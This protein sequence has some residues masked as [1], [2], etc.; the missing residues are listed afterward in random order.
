MRSTIAS[1]M[2]S[3]AP[4]GRTAQSA[5]S[6]GIKGQIG[7]YVPPWMAEQYPDITWDKQ[8]IDILCARFVLQP[9][10]FDV[11]VASNMCA[12]PIFFVRR[13][14]PFASRRYTMVCTVV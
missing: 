2:A 14:A 6:T 12:L 13:T 8:H 4:N 11:V 3:C 5:G 9:D 7:W 10:R 1:S